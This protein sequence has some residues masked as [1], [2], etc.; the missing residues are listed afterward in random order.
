MTDQQI[1]LAGDVAREEPVNYFDSAMRFVG[2]RKITMRDGTKRKILVRELSGPDS[3]KRESL[4]RTEAKKARKAFRDS[5][6]AE[7]A[8]LRLY[9]SERTDSELLD[10]ISERLEA[11]LKSEAVRQ[12]YVNT[13][14]PPDVPLDSLVDSLDD[15]IATDEMKETVAED[16]RKYVENGLKD[17][18][19]VFEDDRELMEREAYDCL[20]ES[21]VNAI[22]TS[23]FYDLS[24]QFGILNEDGTPFF[25]EIPTDTPPKLKNTLWEYYTDIDRATYDPSS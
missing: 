5:D 14:A 2:E 10:V 1:A 24:L 8:E 19:K 15:E 23:Y 9:V 7:A 20:A 11:E 12:S 3:G 6:S 21:A 17:R 16:R 22:F 25:S 13:N 18:I 4:A